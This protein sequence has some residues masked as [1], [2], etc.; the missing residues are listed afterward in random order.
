MPGA[1]ILQSLNTIVI[2]IFY[3]YDRILIVRE[4]I[5]RYLPSPI[6]LFLLRLRLPLLVVYM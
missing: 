3:Y 5:S 1:M 4:R 2:I 6:P